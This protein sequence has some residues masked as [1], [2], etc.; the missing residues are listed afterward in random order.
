MKQRYLN[1]VAESWAG[2]FTGEIGV[3]NGP[4]GFTLE[5]AHKMRSSYFLATTARR[6]ASQ[7]LALWGRTNHFSDFGQTAT[8]SLPISGRWCTVPS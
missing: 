4:L 7:E 1:I 2:N 6:P 3:Q 5:L 8:Y